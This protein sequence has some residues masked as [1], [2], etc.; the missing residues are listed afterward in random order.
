MFR[1]L[2]FCCLLL[3]ATACEKGIS[4]KPRNADTAIVVE[5]YIE[6]GQPPTVILSRSLDYFSKI[7]PDILAASFI[8]NAE[9]FV[10]NGTLTHKLKEYALPAGNGYTVYY[11]SIDSTSLP[12]AFVGEFNKAYSLRI[13]IDGKDYTANTTIP[14]LAKQVDSLWWKPAPSNP[15]T[16]KVV[17]MS[18]ATDPPGFGNY[19]RYYT[20]VNDSVFLPPPASVF[21]DQIIDGTTYEVE[22]ENGVDRN[23]EIDFE[24]YSFFRRGDTVTL[25]FANI[26]KATYDFWRTMEFSYASIGNPFSSPTKVLGNVKGALGYFGGYAVQYK[27]I[28]IPK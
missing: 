14:A 5:A 19:I 21:D 12:T 16:T 6:N 24:E 17:V 23:E 4:F 20:K 7:S 28:I 25:K 1:F 8:R 3:L 15:D 11:Y 22:V 13:V 26:D 10:S 27:T 18:R 9:V 2:V